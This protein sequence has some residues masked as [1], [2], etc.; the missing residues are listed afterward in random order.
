MKK[1][2]EKSAIDWACRLLTFLFS[3]VDVEK[4]VLGECEANKSYMATNCGPACRTCDM[5]DF[6]TRCPPLPEGT[7]PA[8]EPG[9]L[10][11]MFT[12]IV[13]TAPGNQT[14]ASVS[15]DIP[16]YTVTVHSS[17]ADN[18]RPWVVTF[19][20]FVTEEEAKALI[21]HGYEEGYKRSEDVGRKKFDGSYDSVQSKG[22]TSENAWCKL[23][24][25][26]TGDNDFREFTKIILGTFAF[27]QVR[28]KRAV[29]LKK[30][31]NASW[32]AYLP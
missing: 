4:Q 18:G 31:Q 11:V 1:S 17:P 20:N 5:L 12:R 15:S 7:P 28:Q 29:D 16:P 8:L 3:L 2:T 22:R 32:N 24:R 23:Y 9:D 6:N 26:R 13:N 10:D 30:F 25:A 21:E 27:E 19:E 14:N